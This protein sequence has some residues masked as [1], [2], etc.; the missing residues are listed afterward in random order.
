[1]TIDETTYLN[2]ARGGDQEAFARLIDPYC[3]KYGRWHVVMRDQ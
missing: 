3:R 1:M 2:A